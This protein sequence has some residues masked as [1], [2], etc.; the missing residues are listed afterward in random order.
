MNLIQSIR[1]LVIRIL[2]PN[3]Y[4]SE[5][6]K[7]HLIQNGCS[8]GEG[9]YFFSPLTTQIDVTRPYLLEIGKYCKITR[10]VHILTHD[11]SRSVL[12]LKYKEILNSSKVTKIGD[13]V[14][15]GIKSII[16]PGS[17]IGEN[18]IIGAGSVVSGKIP[19]NVVIG[20]NPAKVIMTLEEFYNKRKE[21]YLEE[22]INY[23]LSIKKNTGN[24]P[25]IKEMGDY[26]PLYYSGELSKLKTYGLNIKSNGDILDDYEESII[27]NKPL[28]KDYDIFIS[29]VKK[30]EV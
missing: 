19:S 15:I 14:F 9:T 5:V 25:S 2:H 30:R 29:E 24:Y 22:A 20:G 6:Y 21:S 13:N 7:K 3:R 18:V 28:F 8:I 10:D 1:K 27:N 26:F 4:S 12:R 16:L 23:A 17:N 11:Y